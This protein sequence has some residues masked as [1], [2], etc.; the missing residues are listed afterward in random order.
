MPRR[1]SVPLMTCV[2][3]LATALALLRVAATV[4]GGPVADPPA[5]TTTAVVRA[6]YDAVNDAL[7]TG[8][9]A[10]L[11]A[12]AAPDPIVHASFPGVAPDLDGLIRYLAAVRAAFPMAHL[13]VEE[14]VA[15]DDRALARLAVRGAGHGAFLGLPI[16]EAPS[17]WGQH[18]AVRV[19]AG[20]V[21]ELWVGLDRPALLEPL[22]RV[23]LGSSLATG[24][25]VALERL[26]LPVGG[27]REPVHSSTSRLIYLDRGSITLAVDP[28]SPAPALAFVAGGAA[29]LRP[30]VVAPGTEL[31]LT[32]GAAVALRAETRFALRHGGGGPAPGLVSVAFPYGYTGPL[33]PSGPGANPTGRGVPSAP[34]WTPVASRSGS[35]TDPLPDSPLVVGFG[36]AT[37]SPRATLSLGD[38]TGPVLL[39]VEAGSLAVQTGN[40][41]FV[42]RRGASGATG[43]SSAAV[44]GAGDGA[45]VPSGAAVSL[46]AVGAAPAAALVV[47]LLPD[48]AEAAAAS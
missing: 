4:R 2:L 9:T 23:P 15:A 45:I 40:G 25:G 5:S 27:N 18:D 32:T 20:R 30:T 31:P 3:S 28:A 33:Q 19:A 29:D 14:V 38:A 42:V 8:E 7:R 13:V 24:R 26:T 6:F 12:M 43:A 16:G 39:G 35:A 47:T 41:K 1:S 37:L 10:A 46:R 34:D 21:A 36:R 17:V 11:R 22:Q 44:L 48:A